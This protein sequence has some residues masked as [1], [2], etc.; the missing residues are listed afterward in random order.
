MK[1]AVAQINPVLGQFEDNAN[2]VLEKVL[3]AAKSKFDLVLFPEACLF[4]Y[5]P[6]DLL[7]Q[8]LLVQLQL[9]QLQRIHKLIPKDV[10]VLIGLFTQNPKE[11]GRPLHNSAALL[12]RDKPVRF[13]HKQ[14]L[15][16]GDVFDE[17]RFIEPGSTK[18]NTFKFKSK[19]FLVTICEDIWA[20]DLKGR[21]NP[22]Q[23][24]P[25][26]KIRGKFDFVLNLSASPFDPSKLDQ[27]KHLVKATAKHFKAPTIYCN[28]VGAQDEI[29]FDG[30]SFAYDK[31]GKLLF[32]AKSFE[33]DFVELDFGGKT[34]KPKLRTK[35]T[36]ESEAIRKALVLGIRDF[37]RKTGFR[38]LHLGLS[39]GIDSAVVA[40][41]A[42]EAVGSEHVTC[43]GL[44][45]QFNAPESLQY[46][47]TL[48]KNLKCEWIEF[49]VENIFS[50]IKNEV[51]LKFKIE[52]FG[53]IHEN[54]QARIRGL[55]LMAYANHRNSLLLSTS[56]KSEYAAGYSTLYGDMCG[57]LAPIGDL[58]KKQVYQL[59]K[60][61]NKKRELIPYGVITRPPSAELRPNQKDQDSLPEYDRLDAAVVNL[62]QKSRPAKSETENWLLKKLLATEF[63]RWQ[64][65][66][67]LKVS[68]HAF[69][70]GRR[71]PVSHQI[72]LK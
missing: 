54:M 4:G 56:N 7:E 26:K 64:A 28:L 27:R 53:L 35:L 1:I 37:C 31:N 21:R 48:A 8:S 11:K 34:V 47:K 65:P 10:A 70:R 52:G 24:N 61:Y 29:I 41:L 3:Q 5:H 14:L 66:P 62:I 69:G 68:A 23:E 42:V 58:T 2:L 50:S 71:W 25:L 17:M 22:Y 19:K 16:T 63:K 20:W 57:G 60:H 45:T 44:P 6:F 12:I 33:E 46:A 51:D 32:Q 15:P 18:D 55:I 67:I 39:G 9:K 59:A 36:Q 13:F 30:S 38:R 43:V 49:P 40:C 72:K